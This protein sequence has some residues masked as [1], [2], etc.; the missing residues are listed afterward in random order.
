M[1]SQE[2]NE[3]LTRVGRGTP[4]GEVLRRYWHPVGISERVTKK[5]TR[6]KLL[7]EELVLYRGDSGAPV[8]MQLR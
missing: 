4:M 2:E 3:L 7:G 8:V 6:I 1:L 5:P